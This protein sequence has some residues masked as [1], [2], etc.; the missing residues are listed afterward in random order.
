M[1]FTVLYHDEAHEQSRTHV[2]F[3]KR[4]AYRLPFRCLP[5]SYVEGVSAILLVNSLI[6]FALL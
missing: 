1:W 6:R 5:T 4:R 2:L 3:E